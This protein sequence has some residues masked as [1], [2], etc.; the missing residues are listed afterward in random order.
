MK[1]LFLLKQHHFVRPFVGTIAEL[2]SRGHEVRI[3][4]Q[5]DEERKATRTAAELDGIQ[6][7]S[8]GTVPGKRSEARREVAMAR[9][10]WNYLRYLEPDYRTSSKLRTRAF[11]KL[12]RLVS[13]SRRDEQAEQMSEVGLTMTPRELRFLMDFLEYFESLVP[14]EPECDAVLEAERPDVLLVSP[15]V[16]LNSSTQAD[17]VKSARRMGIPVGLLVYS[18]DNLTTKG[19]IHEMPDR[20]FVW[21]HRQRQE[22]VQLHRVPNDRVVVTGAPRFDP[23][24]ECQPRVPRAEFCEALGFEQTRPIVVYVCSSAFVSG[25][26]LPFVER[27]LAALRQAPDENVRHCNVLV[28]PHPDIPLVSLDMPATK[29]HWPPDVIGAVR[30]PFDDPRAVVFNTTS[31][32]P[33]GLFECLYHCAAAVGLNTSAEIEAGLLGKPVLTILADTASADGQQGTLHFHYLLS[34]HGGFVDVAQDFEHHVRQ[35]GEVI[36]PMWRGHRAIKRRAQHF[37]RPAGA[38]TPVSQVL[39]EA[40]ERELVPPAARR[41]AKSPDGP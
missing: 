31:V 34:D 8:W 25:H 15:L 36:D 38:A 4:W 24:L 3:L 9:R 32:T 11:G 29:V 18:W 12:L 40:I 1:I 27:W 2:A 30:R 5:D 19:G 6:G 22:A 7:V 41:T 33:Q 39:A 26:E 23:Y 17:F 37:A 14:S 16:D 35:L 28:R 21:N 13:E 10:A 20:V